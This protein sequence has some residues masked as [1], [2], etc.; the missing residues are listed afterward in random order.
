MP[1]VKKYTDDEFLHLVSDISKIRTRFRQYISYSNEQ[2]A[3][4]VVLEILFN[5]LDECKTP[6]S[7][8]DKV[9]VYF[10]ERDGFIEVIDNG[11]GIPL[12]LLEEV[13][14][15]LNMGSNIDTTNKSNMKVATLGQN[16]TVVWQN[17]LRLHHIEEV[18]KISLRN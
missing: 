1:G 13:Y 11:R 14:T 18:L 5:A 9:L 6:R 8:A 4:A 17:M 12:D 3:H 16:G 7:P 15:S 10:D 2:G